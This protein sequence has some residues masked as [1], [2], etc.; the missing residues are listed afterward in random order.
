MS[1]NYVHT[2]EIASLDATLARRALPTARARVQSQISMPPPQNVV[3]SALRQPRSGQIAGANQGFTGCK[4]DLFNFVKKWFEW[5]S[6]KCEIC[7]VL[8]WLSLKFCIQIQNRMVLEC[9]EER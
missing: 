2:I 9:N 8:A 6:G 4:D 3:G 1:T 5:F 7:E